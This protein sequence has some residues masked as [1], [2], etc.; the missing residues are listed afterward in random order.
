M[1]WRAG[2]TTGV[3]RVDGTEGTSREEKAEEAMPTVVA[4]S[5]GGKAGAYGH[6]TTEHRAP[7]MPN[8]LV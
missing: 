4:D 1:R 7:V 5:S 8:G 2:E 3:P 6:R